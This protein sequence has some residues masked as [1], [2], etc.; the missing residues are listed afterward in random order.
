MPPIR[1]RGS[2]SIHRVLV[3]DDNKD[4]ADSFAMLLESPGVEA[5]VAYSGT[6]ALSN[7]EISKGATT[8]HISS[9][10]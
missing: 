10:W 1:G 6:E 3:V 8:R 2:C 4:G 7:I 9:R 5:R